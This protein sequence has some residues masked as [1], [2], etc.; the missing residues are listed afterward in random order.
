M[1]PCLVEETQEIDMNRLADMIQESHAMIQLLFEQKSV[2][3]Q[4]L[5][6]LSRKFD[7]VQKLDFRDYPIP[8]S[9]VF[10]FFSGMK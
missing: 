8:H 5:L 2:R 10:L 4:R 1:S 9:L 6:L 3:Y 7:R